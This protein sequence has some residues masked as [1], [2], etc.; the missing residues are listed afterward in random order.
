[1][2]LEAKGRRE[3]AAKGM[4][5]SSHKNGEVTPIGTYVAQGLGSSR[6]SL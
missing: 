6:A 5:Q 3:L 1:M 4:K 2:L